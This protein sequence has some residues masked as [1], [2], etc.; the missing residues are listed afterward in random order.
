MESLERC[1][2]LSQLTRMKVLTGPGNRKGLGNFARSGS[3]SRKN[4]ESGVPSPWPFEPSDIRKC[5]RCVVFLPIGFIYSALQSLTA[6]MYS[7]HGNPSRSQLNSAARLLQKGPI[8]SI[9]CE[10]P[11][12]HEHVVLNHHH[13][14]AD[15]AMA[16]HSCRNSENLL[17][18]QP[19]DDSRRERCVLMR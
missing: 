13:P 4:L 9:G 16:F 12:P 15:E 5:S 8:P 19:V 2:E 14:D 7:T 18:L 3:L 1:T 17:L 10:T 11:R 6:R